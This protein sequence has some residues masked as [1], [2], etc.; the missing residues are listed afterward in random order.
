VMNAE[1]VKETMALKR[2]HP[3][4]QMV[5]LDKPPS[6]F[7]KGGASGLDDFQ[8]DDDV[9]NGSR[10]AKVFDTSTYAARSR[11]KVA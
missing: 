8:G 7:P 2:L 5:R 3:A 11:Q 4:A 9:L 6:P 10:A 1:V